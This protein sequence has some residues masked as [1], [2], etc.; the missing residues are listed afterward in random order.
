MVVVTAVETA[1][2]AVVEVAVEA[3]EM[4][5]VV[6]AA[7]AMAAVVTVAVGMAQKDG[8]MDGEETARQAAWWMVRA[9]RMARE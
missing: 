6:K 3:V 7:V 1:A 8:M 2:E 4:A 9:R 5:E